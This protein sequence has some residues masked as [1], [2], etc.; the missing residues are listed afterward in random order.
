MPRMRLP[1][2][3]SSDMAPLSG[4]TTGSRLAALSHAAFE[5]VLSLDASPRDPWRFLDHTRR[6]PRKPQHC[7]RAGR[8]LRKCLVLGNLRKSALCLLETDPARNQVSR[9]VGTS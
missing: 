1:K 2:A 7:S 6:M 8:F 3:L 4:K 9:E 5:E